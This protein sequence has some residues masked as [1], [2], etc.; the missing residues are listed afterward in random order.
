MITSCLPSLLVISCCSDSASIK[1]ELKKQLVPGHLA[2]ILFFRLQFSATRD[3]CRLTVTRGTCSLGS[4]R[5]RSV[6]TL[7]GSLHPGAES[8]LRSTLVC[9]SI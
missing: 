3:G 4:L 8:E 9:K 1:P 5:E 2:G 6:S 7:R